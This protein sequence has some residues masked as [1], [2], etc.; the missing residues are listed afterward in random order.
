MTAFFNKYKSNSGSM[1]LRNIILFLVFLCVINPVYA[2]D[3]LAPFKG[4]KNLFGGD[5]DNIVVWQAQGQ[6]VKIVEQDWDRDHTRAPRNSH[7]AN[8][9][10]SQIS[11][12]LASIR[13]W[14]PEGSPESDPSVGLFTQDEIRSLSSRLS[15]ALSKAGPKQ[16][17]V[18]AVTDVHQGF[19]GNGRR[20]TGARMFMYD[21]KLNIIFGDVLRPADSGSDD[22]SHYEKPRRAGK[23]MESLGRDNIVYA[24]AGM[25]YYRVFERPRLDWIMM[26]VPAVVAAYRGP[27]LIAPAAASAAPVTAATTVKAVIPKN[28]SL[29]QE[30]RRLREELAHLRK[31]A[32]EEGS[33]E[34]S[35]YEQSRPAPVNKPVP[36]K[37]EVAPQEH[38]VTDDKLE[39]IEQR[40]QLLKELHDK[41]L[42]TDQEYNNK[43]SEI[44]DQ[45]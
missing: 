41:G 1:P 6:Y 10:P 37:V 20:A 31:Q 40:L 42:I 45:I 26:D 23:R 9:D 36:G 44:V 29:S 4:I 14:P 35:T 17:V 24:G 2:L 30:N 5:E 38:V 34:I 39:S 28:N 8:I 25:S 19:S 11:I 13:A 43:R 18:F 16:D 3:L 33:T 12:V 21:G 7:P 27:E 15:E 22:I 32:A